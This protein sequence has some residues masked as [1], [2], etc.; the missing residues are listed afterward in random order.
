MDHKEHS[1]T[2]QRHKFLTEVGVLSNKVCCYPSATQHAH[3]LY[4]VFQLPRAHFQPCISNDLDVLAPWQA[5]C[6][7]PWLSG[8]DG[9]PVEDPPSGSKK[10]LVVE[11]L[12]ELCFRTVW[13]LVRLRVTA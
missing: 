11:P 12:R 13:T 10:D 8:G 3:R 5:A 1:G 7:V 6:C 9:G 2:N 4:F